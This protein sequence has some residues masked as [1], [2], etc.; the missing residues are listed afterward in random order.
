MRQC[1]SCE[2]WDELTEEYTTGF[3]RIEPPHR[4]GGWPIT[5]RY[6]W[7]GEWELREGYA[8]DGLPDKPDDAGQ[9]EAVGGENAELEQIGRSECLP[10]QADRAED[11]HQS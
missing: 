10:S 8:E 11:T 4:E 6:D 7:C 2:Y 9:A 5:N 1:K 3:C